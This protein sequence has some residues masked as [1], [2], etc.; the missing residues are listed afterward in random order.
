MSAYD[1]LVK[2]F[3]TTPDESD[4]AFRPFLRNPDLLKGM[5]TDANMVAQERGL[6]AVAEF[7]RYAGKA[8]GK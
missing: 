6:T 5:V 3:V 4:P 2:K 8:G 1:E 7:V